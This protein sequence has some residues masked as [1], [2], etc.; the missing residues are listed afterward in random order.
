V[1]WSQSRW[2]GIRSRAA[3]THGHLLLFPSSWS[4][5][6]HGAS[7][8]EPASRRNHRNHCAV[9]RRSSPVSGRLPLQ[10]IHLGMHYA[11]TMCASDQ[12]RADDRSVAIFLPLGVPKVPGAVVDTR[13]QRPRRGAFPDDRSRK[14]D[15]QELKVAI[16][17]DEQ[18]SR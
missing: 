6:S 11:Y 14:I 4:I 1:A 12:R 10:L 2:Q 17:H 8:R 13:M 7:K 9:D 15:H 16:W 18:H 5:R 3:A